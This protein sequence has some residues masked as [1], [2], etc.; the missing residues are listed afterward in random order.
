MSRVIFGQ[1]HRLELMLAVAASPDGIV[2]LT[3]LAKELEV[4]VSSLQRPFESLVQSRL[5]SPLPDAD[6]R[7]RYY[8]RNPSSAWSWARELKQQ[9]EN[10]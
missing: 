4:S 9:I 1:T 8:A 10:A 5:L 6:S 2:C 3:E 7:F